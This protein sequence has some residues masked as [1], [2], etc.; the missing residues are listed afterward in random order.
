MNSFE[1]NY[2]SFPV[3]MVYDKIPLEKLNTE[4]IMNHFTK[5]A[6]I[7]LMGVLALGITFCLQIS[8]GQLQAA[9]ASNTADKVQT[10]TYQVYVNRIANCVTVYTKDA[11]G[12]YIQCR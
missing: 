1:E 11:D 10:P 9:E 4:V 8:P 3:E 5:I 12:E 2:W 6:K 7:I